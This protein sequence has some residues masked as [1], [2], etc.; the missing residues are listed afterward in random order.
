MCHGKYTRKKE[1]DGEDF[2]GLM[3]EHSKAASLACLPACI[4]TH[5]IFVFC[6]AWMDGSV[7]MQLGGDKFSSGQMGS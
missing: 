2:D 4:Y 3:H 7:E 6:S 1:K 5:A